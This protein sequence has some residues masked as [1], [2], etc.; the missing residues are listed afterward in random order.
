MAALGGLRF[1]LT[2]DE[3]HFWHTA[4]W[5]FGRTPIPTLAALRSYP[6]LNTPL[7]LVLW[8]ELEYWCGQGLWL[9]RALNLMLSFAVAG[10]IVWPAGAL[11]RRRVL[12]AAGLLLCPYFLFVSAR[13]YTDM[14]A[15]AGVVFGL[16]AYL[17]RR[18]AWSAVFFALAIA[19]RQYALA[20]PLAIVVY[21]STR[22]AGERSRPALVAA[23]IA[24]ATLAGWVLVFGDIVPPGPDAGPALA[25]A[26]VLT[27]RPQNALYLLSCAG[28]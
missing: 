17:D 9:P 21:E 8:G 1:P 19:T 13:L 15:I 20:F 18:H 24:A 3:T 28:L 11:S 26:G 10:L 7:P 12:A 6:E 25:T 2:G 27:L 23:S 16:W 22:R 4:V 5:F 14:P